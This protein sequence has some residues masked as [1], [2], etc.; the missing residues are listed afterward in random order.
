M[1]APM[2][3]AFEFLDLLKRG[4][5]IDIHAADPGF[6]YVTSTEILD[7][8]PDGEGGLVLT[9]DA[10]TEDG[11]LTMTKVMIARAEHDGDCDRWCVRH[12]GLVLRF[13]LT[14]GEPA[15]GPDGYFTH[16][17][18]ALED[19][20]RWAQERDER[21]DTRRRAQEGR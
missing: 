15:F 13:G 16:N 12:G 6:D 2:T 3:D 7:S 10:T 17:P 5:C 8:E 4:T 9:L 21:R 14:E 20:R 19:H 1:S 18:E 11:H